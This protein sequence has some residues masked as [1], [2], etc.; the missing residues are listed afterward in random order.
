ML[1]AGVQ[2]PAQVDIILFTIVNKN[3]GDGKK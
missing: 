1:S 3:R 2:N